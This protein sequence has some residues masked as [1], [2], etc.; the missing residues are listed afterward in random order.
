MQLGRGET[1]KAMAFIAPVRKNVHSY[2][3][4][5]ICV[6]TKALQLC[7]TLCSSID[8]SPPSSSVNGILPA[9]KLEWVARLFLT[10]GLNPRLLC[11][12]HRHVGPL[13]L[14]PPGKLYICACMYMYV[15]VYICVYTYVCAY[16]CTY[17]KGFFAW[18]P[19]VSVA[20]CRI[21]GCGAR[22]P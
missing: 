4:T 7:P 1:V 13:P 8:W 15:C 19:W 22:A 6:H 17:I 5:H 16:I 11:L 9:R 2:I 12:L 21:F 18:L 20:A 10:Q 14:A 3:Y